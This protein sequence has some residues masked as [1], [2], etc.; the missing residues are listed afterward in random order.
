M[1]ETAGDKFS[2]MSG[3]RP[4]VLTIL[5]NASGPPAADLEMIYSTLRLPSVE[6]A[7]H[8]HGV[9]RET[10]TNRV[11]EALR[12][13][14]ERCR[15]FVDLSWGASNKGNFSVELYGRTTIG[16]VDTVPISVP[17]HSKFY[18]PKYEDHV[19]K[20]LVA[21][22]HHGMITYIAG[23]YT[24]SSHDGVLGDESGF[25]TTCPWLIRGRPFSLMA[26]SQRSHIQT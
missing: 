10:L 12:V 16:S 9:G 17:A 1:A 22:S 25:S 2:P 14:A 15:G 11:D 6:A 7:A 13:V 26:F 4:A 18:Q 21:V 8:Y 3:A 5:S 23:P 20:F 24:G 19:V